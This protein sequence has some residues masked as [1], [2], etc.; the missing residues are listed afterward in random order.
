MRRL[1]DR[2][3]ASASVAVISS[4]GIIAGITA[5]SAGPTATA[6]A[7]TAAGI[8]VSA[9]AGLSAG[10][11]ILWESDADQTRDLDEIAA[12]GAKWINIDI[13]WN[14]IQGDGP[15]VWRWNAATDR[16]VLNARAH[17]LNIIGTAAY[18]PTWA[19]TADCPAGELHCLAAN[20]DDYGR[21]VGA[22]AA[23]YGANSPFDRLRGSITSWQ[24]WN[25]P[26]HQE[27]SRPRPDLDRYTA[28]L[29]SAFVA[30]KAADPTATVITGGT[31][32]APDAPDGTDYSPETWLRGLYARGAH[33]YFDAVGHHPYMFP[34]NPLEAHTWNAFTQTQYLYDVMVANGDANKKVWGTEMGAPTGTDPEAL[35]EAQQAQWV[36]DYF[37]GWNTTFRGFTGPMIWFRLRDTGAN[38][39]NRWENLG[40]ERL[41][42]SRKPGY[43]AFQSV[44]AGGV[45]ST[46]ADYTGLAIPTT[47]RQVAANPIGGFYTLAPDGTVTPHDGAPYFG[48]PSFPGGLAR[49]LVVTRDGLGYLVLDGLGGVHKFGNARRQAL[50]RRT[51][52]YFGFDIAR[53]IALTPNGRG[54]AVLDG[55][56][57]VHVGGTAPTYQL[58]YWPGWDIVRAFAYAPDGGGAYLLDAFGGVHVGGSAVA[59]GTKYW[60][61]RDNARDIVIAPDNA[62]YAVLDAFGGVHAAG[63]APRVVSNWARW[64]WRHAGGLA[65]TN[66]GYLVAS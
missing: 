60:Q 1:L 23:R 22:A 55:F 38:L 40:L 16:V 2:C 59:R 66:G 17:G 28:M 50:G 57:G 61:G 47:G 4:V 6:G 10:P 65:M 56:G 27:F 18:S 39:G 37:L 13:D 8:D 15:N 26:N 45:G 43:V 21:F 64:G 54:Y 5:V 33:G 24:I 46:T 51:T 48:S 7:V 20:P 52:P 29:K 14:H 44:M 31:A 58:G 42:G 49:S 34:T 12:S 19:R 41:D 63:S 25:E 53:D 35:T 30:V 9:R 11:G 3:V 36:H 62:G 32:P